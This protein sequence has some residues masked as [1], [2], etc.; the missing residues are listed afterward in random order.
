MNVQASSLAGELRPVRGALA[1][2]LALRRED[3]PLPAAAA[4]SQ[5]RRGRL[6]E[7]LDV[8]AAKHLLDVVAALQPNSERSL[9]RAKSALTQYAAAR[10]RPRRHQKGQQA[11]KRALEIATAGG[12]SL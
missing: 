3:S 8:R 11:P 5:R 7:G 1:M 10:A 12:H 6:V 2:A 9:A 4:R